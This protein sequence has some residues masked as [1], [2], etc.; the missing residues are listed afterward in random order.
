MIVIYA[1]FMN[2]VLFADCGKNEFTCRSNGACIPQSQVCNKMADCADLRRAEFALNRQNILSLKMSFS[3]FKFYTKTS[4]NEVFYFDL[5][6]LRAWNLSLG[7]PAAM[8]SAVPVTEQR[9]GPVETSLVSLWRTNVTDSHRHV[10]IIFFFNTPNWYLY[11]QQCKRLLFFKCILKGVIPWSKQQKRRINGYIVINICQRS[12]FRK[13]WVGVPPLSH[14]PI[15]PL[16]RVHM[17]NDDKT[18]YSTLCP[19]PSMIILFS[20]LPHPLSRKPVCPPGTKGGGDWRGEGWGVGGG[21]PNSDDWRKSPAL[22][23]TLCCVQCSDGSDE[24]SCCGK[25]DLRCSDGQCVGTNQ[26][27]DGKEDCPLG[28]DE[29]EGSR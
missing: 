17:F 8:R 10:S 5:F 12:R 26:L 28:E 27:C 23:L 2:S 16:I 15:S 3:S 21:R 13:G 18:I 7:W 14:H 25:D 24:A 20:P 22:C 4:L 6:I 1:I 19:F 9:N 11:V 29:K